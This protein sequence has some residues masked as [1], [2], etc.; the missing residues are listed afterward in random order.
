MSL[1][2]G[3]IELERVLSA[4]K[5]REL[6]RDPVKKDIDQHTSELWRCVGRR[7]G[8]TGVGFLYEFKMKPEYLGD[9]ALMKDKMRE[10]YPAIEFTFNQSFQ[11]INTHHNKYLNDLGYGIQFFYDH[12]AITLPDRDALLALYNRY[13]ESH[14]DLPEL[15][16]ISSP[17]IATDK[18]FVQAMIKHDAMIADGKEFIHDHS[19]HI[20]VLLRRVFGI[21]SDFNSFKIQ[22][23]KYYQINLEK[24]E[25]L[26]SELRKAKSDFFTE[27]QAS[28]LSTY[29]PL[30]ETLLGALVDT[31]SSL[32]AFAPIT[33]ENGIV[34]PQWQYYLKKRYSQASHDASSDPKPPIFDDTTMPQIRALLPLIE[35]LPVSPDH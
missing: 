14:P 6:E 5:I 35:R 3:F 10:I 34:E 17:G 31:V 8:P 28:D 30:F 33:L 15:N 23:T 2:A 9:E 25:R 1:V 24:I 32:L 29:L 20:L 18:D 11:A 19:A 26:K 22:S 7:E 4:E 16:I 13:R 21:Q 27:A 12:L